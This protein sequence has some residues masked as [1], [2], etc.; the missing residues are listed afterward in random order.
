LVAGA[1]TERAGVC[2]TGGLA[3]SEGRGAR[4]EAAAAAGATGFATEG[5][6]RGACGARAVTGALATGEPGATM[7]GFDAGTA[8]PMGGVFLA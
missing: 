2:A 4:G 6:I 5:A 7:G 1:D 8:R 3:E